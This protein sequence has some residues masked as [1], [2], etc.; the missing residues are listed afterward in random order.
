M[1]T[2]E[3]KHRILK[4]LKELEGQSDP[5]GFDLNVHLIEPK[6]EVYLSSID[7]RTSF[8]FWTVFEEILDR[9]GYK[10]TFNPEDDSFGLGILTENDQ[11]LYIGSYGSF[12]DALKAL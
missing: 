4:D 9:S 7:P 12:I 5:L 3:V 6:K 2:I 1:T 11:L 10:I 8:V